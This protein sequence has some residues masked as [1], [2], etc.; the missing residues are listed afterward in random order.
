MASRAVSFEKS[1]VGDLRK[2]LSML[3]EDAGQ[4]RP[5]KET[6][7]QYICEKYNWDEVA[8]ST[9]AVYGE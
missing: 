4:V 1:N 8:E 6:A 7:R 5:Y 9:I 2:Q 3:L